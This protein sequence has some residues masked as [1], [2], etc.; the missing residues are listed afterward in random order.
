MYDPYLDVLYN[1]LFT[2]Y[3]IGWFATYDKELN[4]DKLELDPMLY[5][6]GMNN[7]HFNNF[8]FWRWYLY[9]FT[10]GL[11]IYWQTTSIL[12]WSINNYFEMFDLWAIGTAIYWC[13]VFVVNL[14]L[15]IATNTHNSFSVFLLIA[16]MC[17][18]ICI[19]FYFSFSPT[20]EMYALWTIFVK[21]YTFLALMILMIASCMLCE[22]AWR[23]IHYI[24]EEI[25]IKRTLL[26]FTKQKGTSISSK[27]IIINSDTENSKDYEIKLISSINYNNIRQD[28]SD[29]MRSLTTNDNVVVHPLPNDVD[30][31]VIMNQNKRCKYIF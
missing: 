9:A 4:Y 15:M 2:A 27:K 17:S 12:L 18:F 23:S 8:V 28:L 31:N 21:S 24:V 14:K 13:I 3:P 29:D 6:I 5:D 7:R 26:F 19:I 10:A 22:Y 1:I 16:S 11:I 25:L 20:T 30:Q